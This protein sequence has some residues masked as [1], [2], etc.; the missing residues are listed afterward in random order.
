MKKH[1]SYNLNAKTINKVGLQLST[2]QLNAH[3][4][5]N[6]RIFDYPHLEGQLYI[7]ENDLY[8]NV[9][10]KGSCFMAFYGRDGLMG[11]HIRVETL[12]NA[13]LEEMKRQVAC[14]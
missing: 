10:P 11:K 1:N 8:G 7:M 14:N 3:T 9:M 13:S 6:A 12:K 4:A 2:K 5:P